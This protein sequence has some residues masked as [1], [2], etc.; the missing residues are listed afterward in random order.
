MASTQLQE[1]LNI[2][3]SVGQAETFGY[4]YLLQ[5]MAKTQF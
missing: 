3:K 2:L 5:Q 4:N 1:C